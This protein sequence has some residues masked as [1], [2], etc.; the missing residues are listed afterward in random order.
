MVM[1]AFSWRER[2]NIEA[3]CESVDREVSAYYSHSIPGRMSAW[4]SN[5]RLIRWTDCR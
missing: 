5:M 1:L 4:S 3:K 2:G